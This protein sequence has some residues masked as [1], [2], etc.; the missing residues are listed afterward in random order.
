MRTRQEIER[1]DAKRDERVQTGEVLVSE[2]E[3]FNPIEELKD[4]VDKVIYVRG[5]NYLAQ[6][7]VVKGVIPKT[8]NS[9]G[10]LVNIGMNGFGIWNG[11]MNTGRELLV[12]FYFNFEESR[13]KE[14]FYA[15]E[16]FDLDGNLLFQNPYIDEVCEKVERYASES[17]EYEP[18]TLSKFARASLSLVGKPSFVGGKPCVIRAI[19]S[20]PTLKGWES[21]M[22]CSSGEMIFD[23]DCYPG[24]ISN[25]RN[26]V[27][28]INEMAHIQELDSGENGEQ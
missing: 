20:T 26:A 23:Y 16:I 14:C 10:N 7:V 21:V 24:S 2:E 22:R 11:Q 3:S 18:L 28:R 1:N 6:D 8:R 4:C 9:Q 25:D 17:Y 19:F 27:R 5:V 12:P 15:L 13:N